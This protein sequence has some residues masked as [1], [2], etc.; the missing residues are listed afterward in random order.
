V[1]LGWAVLGEALKLQHLLGMACIGLSLALVDGR[2]FR[3][4]RSG[5]P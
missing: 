4:G 3:R 5:I 1:L 2:L